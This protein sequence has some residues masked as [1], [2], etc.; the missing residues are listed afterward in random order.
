MYWRNSV[1]SS[2]SFLNPNSQMVGIYAERAIQYFI[3]FLVALLLFYAL[4]RIAILNSE[5]YAGFMRGA[6]DLFRHD[7]LVQL[8]FSLPTDEDKEFQIWTIISGNF[9]LAQYEA[10][11]TRPLRYKYRLSSDRREMSQG[12]TI[13]DQGHGHRTP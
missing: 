9:A 2:T 5:M 13:K 6:F 10:K 4:Y 1:T 7:L 11:R 12:N 8:D 3:A